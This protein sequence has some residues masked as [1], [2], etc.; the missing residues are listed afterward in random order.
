MPKLSTAEI[1][2]TYSAQG[3]KFRRR[4]DGGSIPGFNDQRDQASLIYTTGRSIAQIAV[5]VTIFVAH[6]HDAVLSA[7]EKHPP[8]M[9]DLD[10]AP[11]EYH[12]GW[13]EANARGDGPVWRSGR[14][15]SLTIRTAANAVA[16]RA[17][18]S[19]PL[20]ELISIAK[21]IPLVAGRPE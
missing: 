19:V 1:Q 11:A 9:L 10:G 15:H 16:I 17:P 6:D 14:M 3:Y 13:W 5:P 18:A 21:S 20:N 8:V 4:V 12:D 2:P 7:T